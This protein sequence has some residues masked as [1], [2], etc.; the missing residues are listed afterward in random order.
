MQ[1]KTSAPKRISM[2]AE[3]LK[4]ESAS[5]KQARYFHLHSKGSAVISISTKASMGKIFRPLK[6]ANTPNFI[7]MLDDCI[8]YT[9][10]ATDIGFLMAT[11]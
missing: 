4:S 8:C 6:T 1:L 11:W 7:V 9:I 3:T 5:G 2:L 10:N